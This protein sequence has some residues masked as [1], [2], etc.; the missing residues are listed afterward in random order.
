M[1]Y[2]KLNN[3]KMTTIA[4]SKKNPR[5]HTLIM[6]VFFVFSFSCNIIAQVNSGILLPDGQ[7]FVSREVPLKFTK[8]Y[9]VDNQN[10]K[11]SGL[12]YLPGKN[13]L[14]MIKMVIQVNA[15]SMLTL[16]PSPF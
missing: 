16:M 3:S 6:A 1:Q 9:Y 12:I 15:L 2:K 14:A 10:P 11:L 5:N 7:E 13:I 8:S 4:K